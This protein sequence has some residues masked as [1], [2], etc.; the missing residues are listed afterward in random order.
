[1]SR[2]YFLVT[3]DTE[4]DNLWS[5]PRTITTRNAA[6]LP[7]FQALCER[8]GLKPVYLTTYEVAVDRAF[9]EFARDALRRRQAEV[10]LH[11]HAWNSPPLEALTSDD[12]HYQPYLIEYGERVLREKVH[13]LTSLLE[14]AMGTKMVSHR[15]GRWAM[16]QV[17]TRALLDHGYTVD[18]SVTPGVSWASSPGAPGGRGGSDY[19]LFPETPYFVDPQAFGRPG[20]SRLLQVPMTVRSRRRPVFGMVPPPLR[21]QPLLRRV[22]DRALP[23]QWLRPKRGNGPALR[24]LLDRCLAEGRTYVEFMI[25]SSEFMPGGSPY[26][27]EARDT[28]ALFDDLEALFAH[29]SGRF[30]G[31]TLAEFHAVVE[32]GRA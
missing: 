1:M 25:H 29:A 8:Y 15:A 27:P 13:V 9:R 5:R 20:P 6:Y 10:G 26:F 12:L 7:R 32:A 18:C 23:A 17:Y 2:P 14:E 24:A 3:I 4:G 30:Q 28:D 31:A 21:T 11:V 19:T 22:L 16:T